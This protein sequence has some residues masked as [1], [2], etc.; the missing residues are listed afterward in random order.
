MAYGFNDDKS[1]EKLTHTIRISSKTKTIQA[2]LAGYIFF[3]PKDFDEKFED[4]DEFP[5]DTEIVSVNVYVTSPLD[6]VEELYEKI[7]N[8]SLCRTVSRDQHG[9]YTGVSNHIEATVT[10]R[11]VV[12]IAMKSL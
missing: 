3:Y 1:K 6:D 10:F 12:V 9:I 5:E 2:G 7:Y 8:G 11:V 4:G